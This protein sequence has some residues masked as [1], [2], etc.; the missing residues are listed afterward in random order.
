MQTTSHVMMIRPVAFGFNEQTAISNSFQNP[1]GKNKN[2]IN[3]KA[4]QEFDEMSSQLKNAGIDVIIINDTLEPHTPDSI[5]PNNW[6]SFHENG[7]IILYPM[8]AENRRLEKRSD[9]LEKIKEKGFLISKKQDLSHYENEKKYLEGTGS[10]VLDRENKIAYACISTRTNQD[11]LKEFASLQNFKIIEFQ[12]FF[13]EKPVYHTNV[14]M[15]LGEKYCVICLD[16]IT[17]ETERLEV[18]KSLEGTEK[19]I[20][21]IT[22]SQMGSFAGNMLQLRNKNGELLIVMSESAHKSLSSTQ[23][24]KLQNHGKLIVSNLHT[25]ETN[26]G[27]SARCMIAE[28]FLPN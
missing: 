4:Q 17:D 20:I 28:I 23:L 15:S 22:L 27:G 25:I 6:I 13:E 21:E 2:D 12:S 24:E 26:G 9:I 3:D 16:S 5:F 1:D 11:V 10:M 8:E 14:V 7:E 18:K 19:E